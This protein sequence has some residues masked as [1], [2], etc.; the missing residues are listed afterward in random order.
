MP[1]VPSQIYHL[2]GEVKGSRNTLVLNALLPIEVSAW[3]TQ[4]KRKKKSTVA[5]QKTRWTCSVRGET[6]EE[7]IGAENWDIVHIENPSSGYIRNSKTKP[8]KSKTILEKCH[9][10]IYRGT[11]HQPCIE[12]RAYSY[13]CIHT[14]ST[15]CTRNHTT[16][17]LT[18][19]T[20][21]S[22]GI[23]MRA[24]CSYMLV[25]PYMITHTRRVLANQPQR[26]MVLPTK[27][28]CTQL[29]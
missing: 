21:V 22:E 16:L 20:P 1:R 17:E 2:S 12:E 11:E 10:I 28:K 27:T 25:H 18:D 24:K 19:C 13:S 15:V 9:T 5:V 7:I 29:G 23:R 6:K 8:K 14:R 4:K 3:K 26:S